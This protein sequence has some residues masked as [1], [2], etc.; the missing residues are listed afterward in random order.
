[1]LRADGNKYF[2]SSSENVFVVP[3]EEFGAGLKSCVKW[4]MYSLAMESVI[5]LAVIEFIMN[6]VAHF[7]MKIGVPPPYGFLFNR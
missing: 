7:K 2:L 4:N 6:A 3:G 5:V 1:M